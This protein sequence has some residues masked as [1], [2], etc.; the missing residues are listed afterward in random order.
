MHPEAHTPAAQALEGGYQANGEL[1]EVDQE[2]AS[3]MT[4]IGCS[5]AD[6]ETWKA[7]QPSTSFALEL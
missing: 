3:L 2:M 6:M 4:G 5:R 1:T 7:E